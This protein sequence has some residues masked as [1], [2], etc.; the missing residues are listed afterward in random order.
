MR[1]PLIA[2]LAAI[3][4]G[5]ITLATVAAVFAPLTV[6]WV[7]SGR[8][9]SLWPATTS[10]WA[11]GF[12]APLEVA[13]ATDALPHLGIDRDAASF[14]VSLAPFVLSIA[15]AWFAYGSGARA[16]RAGSARVGVVTGVVVFAALTAAVIIPTRNEVL[17]VSQAWGM[18]IPIAVYALGASAG[19]LVASWRAR[20]SWVG[21]LAPK[22]RTMTEAAVVGVVAASAGLIAVGALAV[23]A[24]FVL[25]GS[26]AAAMYQGLH[27]DAPGAAALTFGQ[28]VYLPTAI[29]WA[30]SWLA[31]PGFAMG[32]DALASPA[33]TT[34][35]VQPP[36]PLFALV[37]QHS[38]NWWLLIVLLPIAVGALAGWIVRSRLEFERFTDETAARETHLTLAER[39]VVVG[40]IVA[41][42][43]LVWV[44]LALASSGGIGPGTLTHLGPS[45]LTVPAALAG[46]IGVGAAIVL[47]A[48][49]GQSSRSAQSA[50]SAQ[51]S[52]RSTTTGSGS[53]N[54][55][56]RL[57]GVLK[58]VILISGAGSNLRA[59]LD[60][61]A[62]G[63]VPAEIVAVG[64][65]REA[66]GLAHAQAR[67]IPTF[68]VPYRDFA[69][70]EA[71]GAALDAQLRAYAPDLVVLSGL[72]RLLPPDT[73]AS[74]SPN[75]I[76]THPAYLPEFPGAHAVRD[77]LAA[78]ATQTGASVIVV[79]NGVDTGAILAQARVQILPGDTE[80]A[81]HDRI[82]PVERRLLAD[83]IRGIADG[84]LTL[85]NH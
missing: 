36:I 6:A 18:A 2:L 64:A 19:A 84:D 22:Q 83:V 33:V 72:M 53:S 38:S 16:A 85:E 23:A 60:E 70:R 14:V 55:S 52:P 41:G 68:V 57:T 48:P 47:L 17:T 20:R 82:K 66:A 76:N 69:S 44:V 26:H 73:V 63:R 12:G 29:V 9:F 42:T 50:Q 15:A 75:L 35:S 43:G 21:E 58:L 65:D 28:A 61:I 25:G 40:A 74:W 10:V 34:P 77:A 8:W 3:D 4:A 79:D 46:E 1:R 5:V 24:R 30:V 49:L 67:G 27:V 80:E 81:L 59:L 78:G 56:D 37:P 45:L 54:S 32:T 7:M 39:A 71:W 11:F 62:A 13:I 51:S 31:G